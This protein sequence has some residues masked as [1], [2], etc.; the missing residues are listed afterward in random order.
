MDLRVY[1]PSPP[2]AKGVAKGEFSEESEAMTAEDKEI[3]VHV[4][5]YGRECLYMRYRDPVTGKQVTRSTE[6]KRNSRKARQEAMK[7]AGN[8]EKELQAGTY[9]SPSKVTWT[10]FRTR[11][12]DEVLPSLADKTAGKVYAVFNAV[13]R[14]IDPKLLRSLDAKQISTLQTRLRQPEEIDGKKIPQRAES[15]I[16][17]HLAHLHAALTWAKSVGM[18]HAVPEIKKPHRAKKSRKAT[19]MKG[20]PVTGEELERLLAKVPNIVIEVRPGKEKASEEIAADAERVESWRYYLRGLW[21]SGLRLEESLEL[22][23]DRDDKLTIDLTGKFPMMRIRAELE[24]GNEDRLLPIA[25]E[26]AEFLLA[27]PDDKRSGPVFNPMAQRIKGP[28]LTAHRVGEIVSDIGKAAGI[29]V[30]TSVKTGKV[31][32]AS[33]HDL[34]RSFGDRWSK[35]V[36]PVVLQTLM[37]HE[38]ISTTLRYYVD[39]DAEQTAEVLWA[40]LGLGSV[41]VNQVA[42]GG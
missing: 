29:K 31:K 1:G 13:E 5:D 10:E 12:E 40:T 37:R 30:Q 36:M 41:S 28:R 33:A 2:T 39:A 16:K 3:K 19:P 34:R 6:V 17:G 27:T 26:F 4:V 14:H 7:V 22:W 18:L 9:K 32:F 8:W 23:W 11:Y 21:L 25:P 42:I 15:T 35:K 20:R 38:D 24:K